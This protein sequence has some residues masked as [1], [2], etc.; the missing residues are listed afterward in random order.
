MIMNGLK[1]ASR[2][3][4]CDPFDLLDDW[5]VTFQQDAKKS[6]AKMADWVK[7]NGFVIKK[8]PRGKTARREV[9]F[10]VAAL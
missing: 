3:S 8:A 4:S 5:N 6:V 10:Q 7:E 1:E 2:G 9:S